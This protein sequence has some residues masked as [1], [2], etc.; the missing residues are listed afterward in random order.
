MP[1]LIILII[2][3]I[4]LVIICCILAVLLV[5]ASRKRVLAQ[6]EL[7]ETLDREIRLQEKERE[8][9]ATL[10]RTIKGPITGMRLNSELLKTV[11]TV[12]NEKRNDEAYVIDKI[13]RMY[14]KAEELENIVSDFLS[15]AMDD[16]GEITV[17]CADIESGI[18]DDILKK[19]DTRGRIRGASVPF[20]LIHIDSKR[21]NQVIANIIDNSYKYADTDIDVSFLQTDYYLQMKIEDHG[22][23]VPED[24]IALITKRFYRTKRW[25]ASD[26]E[27]SGLG[28][29]LAKTIM[30]KMEG[31]MYVENTGTG[32]CVT[33]YIRLS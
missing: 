1:I 16:L 14:G 13:D 7:S 29:Y 27:G 8:L 21:M 6:K 15:S 25:A 24:E 10:C 12:D 17:N 32:L 22:P 18:I 19:C 23:G 20:V 11:L 28:L 31:Q 9:V 4:F 30:E 3:L 26:I 2:A 5:S 33:L